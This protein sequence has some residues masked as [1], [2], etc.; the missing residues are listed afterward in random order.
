MKVYVDGHLDAS[1][2]RTGSIQ[3]GTSAI[4]IGARSDGTNASNFPGLIDE[5]A[6]YNR[7][8]GT[9]EVQALAAMSEPCAAAS[10]GDA[11]GA[12]GP[13]R[14]SP[15]WPNPATQ[16]MNFEFR[17][18]DVAVVHAEILDI[19]GRRVSRPLKDQ[20]LPGGTHRFEWDGLDASGARVAPGVY[21]IRLTSG[22]AAAIQR[23]VLLR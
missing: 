16:R 20:L 7:P 3:T 23:I 11:P 13:L 19:A 22:T 5:L 14:L 2:P 10:V 6:V 17:T 18:P 15:P 12:A 4:L 1:A 9:A 8:L 21:L